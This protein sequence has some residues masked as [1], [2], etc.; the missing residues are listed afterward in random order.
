MGK[1]KLDIQALE[2]KW[3]EYWEKEKIFAFDPKSK[4]KMYSIDTPPPTVSGDM[5][6]GHAFSYSQEDFIARYKRMKGFEVFYPFGTDDNGLPTERLIERLKNVKSK[7]MSRAEFIDLCQKTLKEITPEFIQDWK[8]LAVSC[9][10]DVYYSTIDENSQKIS[11]KSFIDLFKAGEIVK[12]DFPTIYCPE[13]Q[14]PVAQAE[15]EDKNKG[16]HF[17]TLKFECDGEILGIATTRPEL[18][19]ACVA[20]FVNPKDK[21]YK[22]IVGKN[23]KVPL[24]GQEVPV[25]ADDSADLEKGTGVLMVCSY[26]DKYDVDAINRHKLEPRVIFGNDGRLKESDYAG[27]SIKQARKKI[28][29]DLDKA[30]LI[31]EQKEIEHVVNAHDKCGTE[32]EFLPVEQWFIK[33]LDKKKDLMKQGRKVNWKP[34]F[35]VKRYENWVDGLDWDWSI[36]RERHFGIPI[37]AWICRKCDH[38]VLPDEKELPV[39]PT[40]TEKKCDKC[41]GVAD[42]EGKV[43]DTWATS[44]LTPQIAASLVGGKIKLP[45]SLRPQ[46]HD[47]IRTWAFYTITKSLLHE[48]KLP[49]EDIAI[50]GFVTLEGQKMSKSKGNAI[51]PHAVMEEYGAD[52]LRY[53]AAGSKLGEDMNYMESDLVAGK[54]FVTK[55]LNATNFVFM[56]LE[57]QKKKPKLVETDRIFLTRLNKIIESSSKAFDDYNYSKVKFDVDGF[58]WRTFADYYLEIVKDRVYNGSADEKASAFW[59]LYQALLSIVKLMAP[60]TPYICEEIYQEHFQKYEGE[61]SVHLEDWP[62]V[63][64]VEDKKED[65]GVWNELLDIISKVRGA[66]SSAQKSM[67][68]EIVLN[69]PSE[70]LKNLNGVLGDLKEVVKAKEINSGD[71]EVTFSEA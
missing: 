41:G 4:K 47:I 45:Y 20:V 28:L 40:Q 60:F 24:F 34:G 57:Y 66:K 1:S 70:V 52:A 71:F 30:G 21:R 18:L 39:D 5:H 69:L 2:K 22:G 19:G 31:I 14:T 9:D 55:I 63:I 48:K 16:T 15:L 51:R 49:W 6:I 27:M 59:T 37:P 25:I 38:V 46:A 36:S 62:T 23:A 42:P 50:S 43:L 53:W 11:Q 7:E 32:I 17:S 3:R 29:E 58:F 26:G 33:V 67:N 10:Y 54:K 56:N 61:R 12:E 13:C 44:S 8:N 64:E 65:E 35:M 68:A